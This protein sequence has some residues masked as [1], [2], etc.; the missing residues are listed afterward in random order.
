MAAPAKAVTQNLS[1]MACSRCGAKPGE[2][3]KTVPLGNAL[4]WTN[5]HNARWS[6][7]WLKMKPA[8]S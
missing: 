1:R 6:A 7:M 8:A 2:H 5:S 4:S 3:C